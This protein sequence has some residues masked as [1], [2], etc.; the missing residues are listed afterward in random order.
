V[1]EEHLSSGRPDALRSAV[2]V[3]EW[4]WG[5]PTDVVAPDYQLDGEVDL[6]KLSDVELAALNGR[7]LSAVA[8]NGGLGDHERNHHRTLM[9]TD[10]P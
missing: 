6:R 7:L 2:K 4:G 5:R 8:S 3:L 1:L 9:R 10:S